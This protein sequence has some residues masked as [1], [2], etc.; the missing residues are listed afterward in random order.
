MFEMNAD[1]GT[2]SALAIG[3]GNV[4]IQNDN[5]ESSFVAAFSMEDGKQVARG[6]AQGHRLGRLR[7]DRGRH[8]LVFCGPTR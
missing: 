4:F 6:A 8:G 5:N 2:G 3:R 1:F 7:V